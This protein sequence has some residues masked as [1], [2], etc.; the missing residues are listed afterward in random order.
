MVINAQN[1]LLDTSLG[2]RS[3]HSAED[4]VH[5]LLTHWREHKKP[6]VHI[7]HISD[8]PE[9]PFFLKKSADFLP[10]LSPLKNEI[11]IEKSKSS[12]F[13]NTS[14]QADLEKWETDTI[15]ITGFTANECVDATT[16]HASDF[17]FTTYVVGDAT[18]MF[19]FSGPDGKIL[20][21]E[22]IQKLTL[23]NLHAFFAKVLNTEDLLKDLESSAST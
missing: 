8:N 22:R 11:I 3:N 18:A 14:L 6:I 23:A 9:S 4:N 13:A 1:A 17:G 21:A 12:A 10:L 2:L 15:V 16:R 7:K 20:T 5:R 19:D